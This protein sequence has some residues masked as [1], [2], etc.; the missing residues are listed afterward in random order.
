MGPKGN[1]TVVKFASNETEHAQVR[2]L[3]KGHWLMRTTNDNQESITVLL[4][5]LNF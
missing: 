3:K 2:V 1:G 5:P 4:T